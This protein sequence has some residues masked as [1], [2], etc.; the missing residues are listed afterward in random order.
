VDALLSMAAP[1]IFYLEEHR[2]LWALL[3]TMR[4]AGTAVDSVTVFTRLKAQGSPT[5]S[6]F[7]KW[8][9]LGWDGAESVILPDLRDLAHRRW[10]LR[11]SEELRDS[12]K[13]PA[14]SLEDTRARLSELYEATAAADTRGKPLIEVLTPEELRAWKPDPSCY[15]VGDDIISRGEFSVL[16]GWQGIGKSMVAKCLAFAGA[17]GTGWLGYP[18]KR[19]FRTFILQGE[20][21]RKRLRAE[22]LAAPD[23]TSEWVRAT[24]P[25]PLAF[26]SA[27]FRSELRRQYDSWP[28]DLLILDNWTDISGTQDVADSQ[29]AFNQIRACLPY[30][31]SM[32]AV[33]ILAHLRKQR[34]GENWRPK[35]GREL[36]HEISGSLALTSK[37]RAAFVLQPLDP[38]DMEDQGVVFCCAKASNEA[39][40]PPRAWRRAMGECSPILDFDLDEWLNPEEGSR[41]TMDEAGFRALFEGGRVHLAEKRLVELIR[42]KG[43]SY[44]TARRYIANRFAHLVEEGKAGCLKLKA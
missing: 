23:V 5:A 8:Q 2:A 38:Q 40:L 35:V 37:A 42:E 19:R 21:S 16:S 24:P 4:A 39:P 22:F 36:M 9:T 27:A 33:L 15:L 14:V 1:S 43:F 31:D 3:G 11:K 29:E 17:R 20:D 7:A 13:A 25:I 41:R 18:V 44:P 32:P 6:D 10:L 12:A 28:F 26:G 30:G 34:G